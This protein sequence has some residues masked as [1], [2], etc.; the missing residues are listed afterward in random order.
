MNCRWAWML[1][2][3]SIFTMLLSD[4]SAHA[5]GMP[6]GPGGPPPGMMGPGGPGMG[7]GM[8]GP[9]PGMYDPDS[10]GGMGMSGPADGGPGM[11]CGPDGGRMCNGLLGDILGILA[12]YGDG[13]CAAPRWFDI[14]VGVMVLKRDN[15]GFNIPFASENPGVNNVVLDTDDL[16]FNYSTSFKLTSMIQ[17]GPG[18]DVE[19]T[20]YGLFGWTSFAQVQSNGNLFSPYS[21]FGTNPAG[22]FPEVDGADLAS[23]R[24]FST[25]NN[26]EVN[27]RQRWQSP[28]CR[29]QGSWLY[30]FRYFQLDE[31]FNYRTAVDTDANGVDDTFTRSNVNVNNAM[32]GMQIGGD[33]WICLL[34]GLRIGGEGKFALLGQHSNINNTIAVVDPGGV[35]RF[36]DSLKVGDVAFLGDLAAYATYR[37][38]YHWTFKAGIQALYLDGAALAAENFNPNPPNIFLPGPAPVRQNVAHENGDVLWYGYTASLEYLW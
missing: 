36:N 18:S 21:Q 17:W 23:I 34:P 20:Y 27:Y 16:N 10:M 7:P 24:Y 25:F 26:Y 37:I 15:T 33:V 12:P 4:S 8:M 6:P 2:V 19:F 3:L 22:G 28:N 29:Y 14:D 31:D 13:G 9:S 38:N 30:G 32:P 11:D 1:P 35:T 5:Q